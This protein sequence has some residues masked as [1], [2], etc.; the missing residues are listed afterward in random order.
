MV[1]SEHFDGLFR[2]LQRAHG[3]YKLSGNTSD[4]GKAE[5]RA[6]TILGAPTLELWDK[7]LAGQQGLGII[8]INEQNCCRW[9]AIDIDQYVDFDIYD[10]QRRIES[11]G[12]PMVVCRS[13]SGG[14]HCFLFTS[15]DVP[16]KLMRQKVTMLAVFLGYPNVE[17]YPKQ[18]QLANERD[19][20]NWLNMPYFG[21]S[22]VAVFAGQELDRDQFIKL[23]LERQLTLEELT[24]LNA[25]NADR[26]FSD[27]PPCLELLSSRGVGPG[28]RNEVLFAMGVYYRL[29]NP[30][31]WDQDTERANISFFSPPLL[32]KETALVIK[33]LHK[34]TYFYPCS[35]PSIGSVCNKEICRGRKF[36]IGQG[37]DD[38]QLAVQLGSLIK[39]MT[40]PPTWII[41]VEGARFELDTEDLMSQD[42]FARLCVSKLNKWPG[43]IKQS[44]WQRLIQ[45]KLDN[46]EEV[47]V[48]VDA[49]NDGRL[50]WFLEQ[51]CTTQAP[52]RNKE[53]LLLGKP[54]LDNGRYFFRSNDLI[55]YMEH[56]HFREFKPRQVWMRLREAG[57]EHHQFILKGKC[58]QCWS[59]PAMQAQSES[60]APAE[61]ETTE[62]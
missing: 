22:R 39:M 12:I 34:K 28:A 6:V 45:E 60:F 30:E 42:R 41:D 31:T 1:G 21:K 33:S 48:P 11:A 51:F 44:A 13:K 4:R 61:V 14:A 53:E 15:E 49:S 59:V 24:A 5:G 29:K 56:Q 37:G 32:N 58:V 57:S 52:A 16:A 55:K 19:V 38:D 27:G 46:V 7:H 36:G 40:E 23:A 26:A 20:G 62:F 10:I 9:G 2:G 3:Q 54:Y 35:K 8:P 18:T 47:P 50:L 17:I 25:T 43:R